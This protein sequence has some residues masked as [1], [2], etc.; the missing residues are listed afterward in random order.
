MTGTFWSRL[1]RV[2]ALG[3]VVVAAHGAIVLVGWWA[4]WPILVRPPQHFIPMAPSTALACLLLGL[5]LLTRI[6]W[7]ERA[8]IRVAAAVVSWVVAGVALLSLAFPASLDRMLGGATGAFGRVPLGVMSPVT[9]GALFLLAVAIGLLGRRALDASV[10]A[11]MAALVGATVALG[12]AYGTPLLYGSSTIPVAL[13]TGLSVL[14][15]GSA[16][17]ATAGAGVWPLQPLVGPSP[18]ARMLRAFL[19]ATAGLVVFLGLLDARFG[20][21]LGANRALVAGWLGVAGVGLVALLVSRLARRIGMELDGAYDDRHRAEQRY[22]GIINLAGDAIVSADERQR[23]QLFNQG[24]ERIFGY[25]ATDVVGQSLDIL[26]PAGFVDAHRRHIDGFAQSTETARNMGERREVFG[27]RKDGT[28]FP[29]EATVSKLRMGSEIVFTVM[30]R[31]VT[32]RRNLERQLLQAQKME[33]VGRLAAGIAHDFNNLLTAIYGST[34]LLL[35]GLSADDERREDVQEIKKAA[36]RAAALTRQ[37]LAFSRQQVLAPQI[38]DLNTVVADVERMLRRLI[39]EDIEFRSVLA[40]GLGAVQADPGQVEQVI[41]NLVVNA[42]DAMPRGGQLAIETANAELDDVYAERH[43]AVRPGRYV[44]LAVSDTGIG[45]NADTKARIF[46]PFFTTKEKGK[47]T[48][49]GLATVYGI[50]KQSSGYIWVYSEPGQGTTFKVY[51]PRVE[52]AAEPPAPKPVAPASL[53][54]TETVL[55]AEDEEAVRNL[56]RRVLEGHGYAVLAARDG[57]E[58]LRLAT[59]HAGPIHLLLTDVVMPSMSGRQLAERLV[60]AR[61]EM[62]VLYLSGYTNDAIVH[63]GMLD[64]GIAFLQKPFTPEALVRKLREV[65]DS[66]G[67]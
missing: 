36:E 53:R 66:G 18:R 42:R 6:V 26:L 55:V 7:A 13:P 35:G 58:A 4:A 32:E 67:L 49:L 33:A 61:S 22:A 8:G 21:A 47:G 28:E 34:E 10:C 14:V 57:E 9:A 64:P 60:S 1:A 25:A 56:T 38:L 31:D 41:M 37:L 17:V 15:L 3:A 20:T 45:M 23:I 16:I 5:A 29:A 30:L 24:A 40:P 2:P 62:K 51:L 44:M 48:G 63:H 52:A 54:G 59:E 11:T 65:L 39:G 19:P 12:Y 27:R 50:V 46:E 43:I